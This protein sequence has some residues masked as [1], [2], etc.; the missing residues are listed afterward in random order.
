MAL[1]LRARA[2]AL[3]SLLAIT[4]DTL[5]AAARPIET[6]R[7]FGGLLDGASGG[8]FTEPRTGVARNGQRRRAD[9]FDRLEL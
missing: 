4:S 8:G 6:P 5:P 1:I 2:S 3:A 9:I 7:G